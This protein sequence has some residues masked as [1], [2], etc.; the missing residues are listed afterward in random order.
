LQLVGLAIN[1]K[2]NFSIELWSFIFA[3]NIP[4]SQGKLEEV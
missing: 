4:K 3:Y 1:L 2:I